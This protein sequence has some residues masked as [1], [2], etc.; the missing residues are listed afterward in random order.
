MPRILLGLKMLKP[1]SLLEIFP[2]LGS[3]A[4]MSMTCSVIVYGEK[5]QT[6]NDYTCT[7]SQPKN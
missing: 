6:S 4:H 7:L 5:W 3:R 1:R 2:Y